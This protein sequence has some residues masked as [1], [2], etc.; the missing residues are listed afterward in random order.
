MIQINVS[1]SILLRARNNIRRTSTD[2]RF[3][4][5]SGHRNST[6]R[7]LLGAKGGHCALCIVQCSKFPTH[8]ITSS[9]RAAHLVSRTELLPVTCFEFFIS[10]LTSN[11]CP[12]PRTESPPFGVRRNNVNPAVLQSILLLENLARESQSGGSNAGRFL[13]EAGTGARSVASW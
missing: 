12:N 4:P 9:A 3:A 11:A 2:V 1:S 8:S 10:G 5:K 6:V 7:C 13:R